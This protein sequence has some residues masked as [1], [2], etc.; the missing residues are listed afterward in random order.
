MKNNHLKLSNAIIR[1]TN[2]NENTYIKIS[3]IAVAQ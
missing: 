2:C 1:H 3:L